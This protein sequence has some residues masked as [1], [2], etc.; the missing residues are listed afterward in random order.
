MIII[1]FNFLLIK[2]KYSK[3]TIYL[4]PFLD[5]SSHRAVL[6]RVYLKVWETQKRVLG[7]SPVRSM[8]GTAGTPSTTALHK[9]TFAAVTWAREGIK[10]VRIQVTLWTAAAVTLTATT[11]LF[12]T[13]L[14]TPAPFP[15]PIVP[16]SPTQTS[17]TGG[18]SSPITPSPSP[19]CFRTAARLRPLW[20]ECRAHQ[21]SLAEARG[22]KS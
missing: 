9:L 17:A 19:P 2:N 12:P 7:S 22:R 16:Q 10:C 13:A 15:Q 6:A 18:R 3:I 5:S 8:P 20:I 1:C 4:P 11:S 14:Y 21:R